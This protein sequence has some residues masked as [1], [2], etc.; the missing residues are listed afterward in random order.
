MADHKKGAKTEHWKQLEATVTEL[1]DI[2]FLSYHKIGRSK[3]E[4]DIQ[5]DVEEELNEVLPVYRKMRMAKS[6]GLDEAAI[7]RKTEEE[8]E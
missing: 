7:K 6:L 4:A 8:D 2:S 1:I 5:A 3:S